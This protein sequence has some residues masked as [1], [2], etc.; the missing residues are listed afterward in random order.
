MHEPN[1]FIIFIV[2]GTTGH[3]YFLQEK[4]PTCVDGDSGVF[5]GEDSAMAEEGEF[6]IKAS[7]VSSS[8]TTSCN[9]A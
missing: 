6:A 1:N 4:Q 2:P 3:P 9:S 8:P 5:A 7:S